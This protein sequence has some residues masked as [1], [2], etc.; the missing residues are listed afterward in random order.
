MKATAMRRAGFAILAGLACAGSAS[1]QTPAQME[2][3]RQ[4]REYWRQQEQQRQ[5]QQRQ[6]QLMNENAARQQQESANAA[7]R[8]QEQSR[9][10]GEQFNQDMNAA[11]GRQQQALRN[12][13]G[14]AAKWDAARA[15]WLKKPALGAD[16]NPLLGRWARPNRPA[17]SSDPFAGLMALAKGGMC[18]VLFGGDGVF[19][20]R[21]GTMVGYERRQ[22]MEL[23]KV[24]YRGD[25]RLVA[26]LPKE[27]L[28]LIVFEFDGPDRI[29]WQ[30]QNCPM[31]RVKAQPGV[32]ATAP[33]AVV[34][35]AAPRQR[36]DD[37]VLNVVAGLG[38]GGSFAPLG[39]GSKFLLLRHSVDVALTGAGYR[40][41]PGVPTF[42][43]WSLEC[44]HGTP[45]C[46]QG[47][48]G[49]RA[50]QV[51]VLQTDAQGK[52]QMARLAAGSYYVFGSARQGEQR[53]RWNVRVD[54]QQGANAVTLDQ[55]NAMAAN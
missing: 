54:L 14:D 34:A 46:Q 45:A 38:S 23:D 27:T 19:E 7:R 10:S 31:V 40:P 8:S 37:A 22:E 21:P 4:Q 16:K 30:G 29:N 5:E 12:G 13:Q 2:Y 51:G 42:E 44:Q 50:D 48:A 55:R 43:A 15:G 49:I 3:D 35:N 1:A 6:Q 18:E 11:Q 39:A 17:N 28:K 52:A 25:G 47:I 36:G 53:A 9:Q 41:P 26:V 32:A 33:A 20:F 24:E